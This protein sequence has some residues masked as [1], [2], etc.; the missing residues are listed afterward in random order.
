MRSGVPSVMSSAV[1]MLV[2]AVVLGSRPGIAAA[3]LSSVKSFDIPPGPVAS[4]L[5]KFSAQSGIQVTS[6]G[7]MLEGE[8]S[9][10]V[11]GTLP[12]R[13][14]LAR[15]LTGTRLGYQVVDLNTIAILP[16]SR[17]GRDGAE[18]VPTQGAAIQG[19]PEAKGGQTGSSDSSREGQTAG[20]QNADVDEAGNLEE[21]VVTASRRAERLSEVGGAVS[22]I[23]GE[24]LLERS[25]D[26]LQ[27][28]VAFIPGLSLT[29]QGASGYGVVAIRGIAPQGNGAS[30][31]TYIDNIPVG[32]SGGTTRSALF[33]ADLDP[34]DL[35]RI[36]VLKGPQG[37]LYGASSMG[38]V[39]K[40]V[41]QE[42]SLT[43][44]NS[45]L[46][47]DGDYVS[48]GDDAGVKLR[49]SF[50]TALIDGVLGVRASVY[51]RHDPGFV[52]DIGVQGSGVGRS[53]DLGGRLSLLYRPS[54]ALSVK[55]SAMVQQS[56]TIGLSVVDTNTT[57]FVPT[58]GAYEQLRYEREGLDESTRLYSAE[59]HYRFG[60]FDF[61]SATGY[62]QILPTGYSDD[63][64]AFQAYGLGPVSPTNPAQDVSH[65]DSEKFTQEFRLTSDRIGIAE[66]IL[67]AFYQH[68][69]D[70]FSFVDSLTLTPEVNF[71]N[72]G[73]EGTL[74]EY[75]GFADATL[76]FSSRFDL[77]LGYRY[78]R[79]DQV[80]VQTS[81]GELYN[82]PD[83]DA[84]SS[85]SQSFSEGPSTYL[86]AARYHVDDD[87]LLY[88]RAASGYRPG[89]G[90][91]LPPGTPPG[92]ADYYTS[93]KLWSYEVGGKLKAWNG[94]LTVDADAFYINW[95][96]IQTLQPIPG[97]PFLIN[98]NS[99]AAVSRGLELQTALIPF[100]G[101]TIGVNGA[102]T[103]AHFTETVP[104]VVND[105]DT[106]TY[107]PKFAASTY[108]Q[109]LVPVGNGWNAL[110]AG[111]YQYEGYRVDT[112]RVPL[113]GYGVWNARFGAQNDRFQI[114]FY[115]KNLTDKYARA[116]SNGGGGGLLP[117]YFV[118]EQPRTF[119][120]TLIERF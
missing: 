38:G 32:A 81:G 59:I 110:F 18:H 1:A 99:G 63:T 84:I 15:L 54:E 5:I 10:G 97:T 28:Y 93:D 68:E 44:T 55:L 39:I 46:T 96:N 69:N 21:I 100:R 78:S 22:A 57:D 117:Y 80:Q 74:R 2:I 4:A 109:Y 114:Y 61:L 24:S 60:A 19:S 14:A 115:V 31:A 23:S 77:T 112:Y 65:D 116:G 86:A 83:P 111:D 49:G 25:A 11:V 94:R 37:T 6:A 45:T 119:G 56:D 41:T 82:P 47:E 9:P 17:T 90:R 89:G 12:A 105:G 95:T 62:S 27:D 36:E 20:T 64:L 70:H 79:I 67:G 3:D 92:F 66:F 91:A 71:A 52:D 118:I 87:F 85:T 33:T 50:T 120:I 98:G 35:Q 51:Y 30:V 43:S 7:E 53:N 106:L 104:G 34:Q 26:S 107:I 108:A 13:E 73:G 113:P 58:Y 76:F 42:P 8:N 101:L 48:H 102:Y 75:A 16:K 88:A 29:S 103:D 72:R 40:Y